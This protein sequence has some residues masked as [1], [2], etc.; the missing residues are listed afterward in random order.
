EGR[1]APRGHE[2][3]LTRSRYITGR[4]VTEPLHPRQHAVAPPARARGRRV[5]IVARRSMSKAGNR[6]RLAEAHLR[7]RR[8]EVQRR[9]RFHADRRLTQLDAIEVLLENL[10]LAEMMLQAE[11]P[12]NLGDLSAPA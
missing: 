5:R 11:R 8:T 1:R 9:R 2:R 6:R 3:L 4:R 7:R 10:L 12:E